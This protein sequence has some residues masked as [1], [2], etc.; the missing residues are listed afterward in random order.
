MLDIVDLKV[1]VKNPHKVQILPHDRYIIMS[2]HTSLYDIP[3]ILRSFKESVRMIAKTELFRVPIWGR[4]MSQSEFIEIDRG[5]SAK[6]LAALEIAKEKMQ[7][8]IVPWIAPEGTRSPD[9]KLGPFKKGGIMM[10]IQTNAIIIPVGIKGTHEV[11]PKKSLSFTR[12]VA[13]TV[14]IG[15]PIDSNNYTRET[16]DELMNL[17]RER[18][19]AN[20]SS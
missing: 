9:G 13:V 5:N 19:A 20:L 16:R 10:A 2:N 6:A 18:I 15:E 17:V 7:S 12:G 4:A 3:V 8:G 14:T 1:I 11:L